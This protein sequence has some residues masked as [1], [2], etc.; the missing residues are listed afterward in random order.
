MVKNN[1]QNGYR[2]SEELLS[3]Q[4][5]CKILGIKECTLYSWVSQHRITYIKI[6]KLNRFH[7]LEIKR[8]I[9]NNTIYKR[10]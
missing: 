1:E 8:I 10:E 4:D 9:S 7:P 6:G 5:V 3:M 2:D